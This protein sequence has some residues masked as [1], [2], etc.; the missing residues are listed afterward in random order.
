MNIHISDN[1]HY[2]LSFENMEA[3]NIVLVAKSYFIY[4]FKRRLIENKK[5]TT[6]NFNSFKIETVF[7]VFTYYLLLKPKQN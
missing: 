7:K 1:I 2:V 6:L 4:L 5:M 3:K